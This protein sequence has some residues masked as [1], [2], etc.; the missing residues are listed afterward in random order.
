MQFFRLTAGSNQTSRP[1]EQIFRWNTKAVGQ[2][3]EA[4][5]GWVFYLLVLDSIDVTCRNRFSKARALLR[6]IGT[7]ETLLFPNSAKEVPEGFWTP[8]CH[9]NGL[10]IPVSKRTL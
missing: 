5:S 6:H 2:S 4:V 1:G 9:P 8:I 3:P 10:H 7:R